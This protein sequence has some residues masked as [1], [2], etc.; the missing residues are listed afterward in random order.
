MLTIKLNLNWFKRSVW[1]HSLSLNLSLRWFSQLRWRV[2]RSIYV[3]LHS[4][5]RIHSVEFISVFLPSTISLWK[6]RERENHFF[7]ATKYAL[8]FDKRNKNEMYT[9]HCSCMHVYDERCATRV[10]IISNQINYFHFSSWMIKVIRH[11]I[12]FFSFH[13]QGMRMW[14]LGKC[15]RFNLMILILGFEQRKKNEIIQCDIYTHTLILMERSWNKIYQ[16]KRE[17]KLS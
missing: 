9:K 13:R 7:N 4:F 5:N 16:N 10:Y 17:K 14:F 8:N 12:Y 2:L 11:T 15:F 6:K 1:F 3:F